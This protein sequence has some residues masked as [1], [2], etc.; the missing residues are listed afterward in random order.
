MVGEVGVQGSEF[1][2]YVERTMVDPLRTF[3]WVRTRTDPSC[4]LLTKTM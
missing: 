1:T 2:E 3:F 4:H